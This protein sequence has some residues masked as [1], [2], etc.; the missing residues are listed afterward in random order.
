MNL[1]LGYPSVRVPVLEGYPDASSNQAYPDWLIVPVPLRWRLRVGTPCT[2]IL[3]RTI[4]EDVADAGF[5]S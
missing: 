1:E 4:M 2:P 3:K 5:F